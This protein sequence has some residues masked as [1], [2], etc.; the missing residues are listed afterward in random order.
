MVV[1]ELDDSIYTP[2]PPN[3]DINPTSSISSTTTEPWQLPAKFY[4]ASAFDTLAYE[5][6]V[7]PLY[8][9]DGDEVT[10]DEEEVEHLV[11]TPKLDP[12]AEEFVPMMAS[13]TMAGQGEEASAAAGF[14]VDAP[15]FVP[16]GGEYQ[17]EEVG[18]CTELDPD[19]PEFIPGSVGECEA[20][21]SGDAAESVDSLIADLAD[22]WV[23]GLS[24]PF[25]ED[26]K[27]AEEV[28]PLDEDALAMLLAEIAL[29]GGKDLMKSCNDGL[30]TP[31]EVA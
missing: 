27:A 9:T 10:S 28:P 19:A 29:D 25:H 13:L 15:E 5:D 8:S 3:N 24:P 11:N 22:L 2:W 17:I 21:H 1:S 23:Q 20:G 12:N 6:P 7:E 30:S 26:D 16:G 14:N 18:S 31:N 4:L